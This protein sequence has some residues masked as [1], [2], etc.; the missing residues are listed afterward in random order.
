MHASS[1]RLLLRMRGS[2][3][4]FACGQ[5][6]SS[7]RAV[8]AA[9]RLFFKSNQSRLFFKSN[10]SPPVSSCGVS[11]GLDS[12]EPFC[13]SQTVS[14]TIKPIDRNSLCQF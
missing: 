9:R 12:G 4:E 14:K 7:L 1:K 13:L 11:T 3:F 5:T 8:Q 10:Q 2:L 6:V